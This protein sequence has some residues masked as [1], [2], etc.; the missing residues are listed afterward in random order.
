MRLNGVVVN[1]FVSTSAARQS[2]GRGFVGLQNHSDADRVSFRGVQVKEWAGE[3]PSL[4]R[5]GRR[6]APRATPSPAHASTAA[7]GT[8]SCATTAAAS[9]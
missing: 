7:A 3:R 2:L 1:R 6:G 8:D 9:T 4:S 5:A